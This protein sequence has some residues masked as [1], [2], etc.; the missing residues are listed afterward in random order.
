MR[1]LR[2]QMLLLIG[3]ERE[4]KQGKAELLSGR[5][6]DSILCCVVL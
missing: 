4:G 6:V 1:A 5:S 3:L 2:L